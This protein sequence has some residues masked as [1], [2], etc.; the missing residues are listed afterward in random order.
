MSP[1]DIRKLYAG[2]QR[3]F[4]NLQ[5]EDGADMKNCRLENARFNNCF[6]FSINLQNANLRNTIFQKCNLK[7]SDFTGADLSNATIEACSVE[8]A[9]FKNS[10][11]AN[12]IF[13]DNDYYGTTLNQQDFDKLKEP[14]I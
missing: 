1:E 2:G 8:A 3:E 11:T 5:L 14:N 10:I 9:M 12:I 7:C 4:L 6:L 13:S